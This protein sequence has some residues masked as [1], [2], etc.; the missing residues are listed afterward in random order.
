MKDVKEFLIKASLGLGI[1]FSVFTCL[2]GLFFGW[3]SD[4]TIYAAIAVISLLIFLGI[5]LYFAPEIDDDI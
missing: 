3:N 1:I 5:E 4:T 2:D